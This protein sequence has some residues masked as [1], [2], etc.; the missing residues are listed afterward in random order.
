MA[1]ITSGSRGRYVATKTAEAHAA[2][3]AGAGGEQVGETL[4]HYA[5]FTLE[6]RFFNALS[7]PAVS[8]C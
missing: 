4:F 8:T 3:A 1:R 6:K 5:A 7:L 2:A